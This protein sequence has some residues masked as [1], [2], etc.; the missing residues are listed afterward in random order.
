M[1]RKFNEGIGAIDVNKHVTQMNMVTYWKR[2]SGKIST[3]AGQESPSIVVADSQGKAKATQTSA[4]G[5]SCDSYRSLLVAACG[6][7]RDIYIYGHGCPHG[8]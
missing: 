8:S 1:T 5:L 2:E 3:L 6:L 7:I 4:I